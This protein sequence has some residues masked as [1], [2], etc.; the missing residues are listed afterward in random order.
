M[1]RI[2]AFLAMDREAGRASQRTSLDMFRRLAVLGLLFIGT[3]GMN[4]GP[5]P[6][7][8]GAA[9]LLAAPFVFITAL[10]LLWLLRRLWA[11][12]YPELTVEARPQLVTSGV[13]LLLA[14]IGGVATGQRG[15]DWAPIA[16]WFFGTSYLTLALVV[17]RIWLSYRP[18]TAFTWAPIAPMVLMV[19]PALVLAVGGGGR[20]FA[21]AADVLWILPGYLGTVTGPLFVILLVEALIRGNAGAQPLPKL[22]PAASKE[23][24]D[25]PPPNAPRKPTIPIAGRIEGPK[26][27][28]G[29]QGTG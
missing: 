14:V 24:T 18:S 11:R 25:T 22:P 10:G 27:G 19:A 9:V 15:A 13:L 6:E 26:G 28:S 29:E 7:E 5:S 1:L 12:R 4:C 17:L 16:F 8:E 23:E 2:M 3:T 21:D 20:N